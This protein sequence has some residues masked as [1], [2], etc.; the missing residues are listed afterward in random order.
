MTIFFYD[1][2]SINNKL[3]RGYT[4]T[5]VIVTTI[6]NPFE[7]ATDIDISVVQYIRCIVPSQLDVSNSWITYWTMFTSMV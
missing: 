7:M 2:I 1:K 3:Y 4:H 5:D 6:T